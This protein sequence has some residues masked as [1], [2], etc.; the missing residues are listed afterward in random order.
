MITGLTVNGE[1]LH[2]GQEFEVPAHL[3]KLTSDE[4]VKA[5]G[6]QVFEPIKVTV[7]PASK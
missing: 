5:Y 2:E 7:T 4:Q 6:R 3:E 1:I